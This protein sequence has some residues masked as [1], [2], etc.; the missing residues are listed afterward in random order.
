MDRGAWWAT[1]HGVMEESDTTEQLKNN[2]ETT[3]QLKNNKEVLSGNFV[4]LIASIGK[5]KGLKSVTS[6]STVRN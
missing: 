4:L 2:K 6:A 1:V 3:Q 5:D